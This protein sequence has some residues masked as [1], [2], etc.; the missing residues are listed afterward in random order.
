[1]IPD[2]PHKFVKIL[3]TKKT[4]MFTIQTVV[5]AYA[6]AQAEI[7]K[8]VEECLVLPKELAKAIGISKSQFYERIRRRN[9]RPAEM[10]MLANLLPG[11][12]RLTIGGP[13]AQ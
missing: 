1:M 10:E 5:A 12:R 2:F 6:M 7:T 8:Q 11:Q 4:K 13:E 9:W 3:Q